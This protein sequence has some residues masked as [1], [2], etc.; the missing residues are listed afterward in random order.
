MKWII[1]KFLLRAT[2]TVFKGSMLYP[3]FKLPI[4]QVVNLGFN[5]LSVNV[6]LKKSKIHMSYNYQF[7]DDDTHLCSDNVCS[8]P[9][10]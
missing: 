4:T 2:K 8:Y 1:S 3:C 6:S 5:R 9:L 7:G 10:F